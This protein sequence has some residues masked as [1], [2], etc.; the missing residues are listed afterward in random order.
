MSVCSLSA[1][2]DCPAPAPTGGAVIDEGNNFISLRWE[3][4]PGAN[5]YEI[6]TIN[7]TDG[8]SVSTNII[9]MIEHEETN[10]ES[11]KEYQFEIRA[12]YC[13]G[14]PYGLPLVLRA[15]T[16]I[17]IVDVILQLE[18]E[19]DDLEPVYSGT[20]SAGDDTSIEITPE[21]EGCYL[22]EVSSINLDPNVGLSMVISANDF[23]GLTLNSPAMEAPAGVYGIV[24][25][26]TGLLLIY[27][28]KKL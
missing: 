2:T 3:E 10:L 24:M 28:F 13:W 14:G 12:S 9:N 16:T 11:G 4:V 6:T 21:D 5:S 27:F 23:G 18:C 8:N 15:A 22:I 17:I 7:L 1:M 19:G 20:V 26:T 25:C